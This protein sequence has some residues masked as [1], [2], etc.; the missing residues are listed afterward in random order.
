M[1]C[2]GEQVQVYK[3]HDHWIPKCATW[4]RSLLRRRTVVG[5]GIVCMF[6]N[7]SYS[8]YAQ[9]SCTVVPQNT[10]DVI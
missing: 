2:F 10:F 8:L 6:S 3:Y 1:D 7:L 4:Y 9:V 5:M